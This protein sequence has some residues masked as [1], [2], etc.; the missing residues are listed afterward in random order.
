MRVLFIVTAQDSLGNEKSVFACGSPIAA[1]VKAHEWVSE[2]DTIAVIWDV[3]PVDGSRTIPMAHCYEE[4]RWYP[5]RPSKE[6]P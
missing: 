3:D 4:D 1:I 6:L 5:G 2:S